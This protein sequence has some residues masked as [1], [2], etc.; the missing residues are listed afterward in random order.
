MSDEYQH[1]VFEGCDVCVIAPEDLEVLSTDAERWRFM[2]NF[3]LT[4]QRC[5]PTIG[6]GTSELYP[7]DDP[8]EAIDAARSPV[9]TKVEP[10]CNCGYGCPPGQ[11]CRHP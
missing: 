4:H 11:G 10:E 1:I 9:E 2:R 5:G 6:W 7:G 8:D 3:G